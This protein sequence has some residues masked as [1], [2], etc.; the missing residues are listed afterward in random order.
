MN[1]SIKRDA[2][3][4][5]FGTFTELHIHNGPFERNRVLIAGRVREETH[6]RVCTMRKPG[7]SRR[8]TIRTKS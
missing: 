8:W 7:L 4:S 1:I 6:K 3:R 5:R 2:F